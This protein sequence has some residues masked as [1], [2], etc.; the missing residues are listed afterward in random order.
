MPL[1]RCACLVE[2]ARLKPPQRLGIELL[3]GGGEACHVGEQHGHDLAHL[4]RRGGPCE[5]RAAGVAEPRAISVLRA[6]CGTR[7]H[8]LLL[9]CRAG[10]ARHDDVPLALVEL[11]RL[12]ERLA[13]L[14]LSTGELQNPGNGPQGVRDLVDVVRPADP[15]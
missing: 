9:E 8:S 6:A 1:D 11:D 5:L 10:S 4:A 14:V 3:A 15:T 2:V 13:S 7:S 12:R